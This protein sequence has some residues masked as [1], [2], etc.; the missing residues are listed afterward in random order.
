MILKKVLG[1]DDFATTEPPQPTCDDPLLV[2]NT[3]MAEVVE[4]VKS[5]KR[6]KAG[7]ADGIPPEF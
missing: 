6:R 7:G 3:S 5:L 2:S 4:S 1:F